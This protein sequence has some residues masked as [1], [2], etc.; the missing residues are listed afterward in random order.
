MATIANN[1]FDNIT[2]IVIGRNEAKNLERC[3]RSIKK[4]N[5]NI[6]Y[7][8]SGSQDSSVSIAEKLKVNHIIQYRAK[9]STPAMSRSIG[10]KEASTEYIQF[11]DGDMKLEDGWIESA[12]RKMESDEKIAIVHG[13]KKVFTKNERDF[14]ILSDKKDWQPDYLQ[15]AYLIRTEK[16]RESGGLDER[17]P[18]E[19]ERDL[20]IRIRAIGSQVWYI[21]QLMASHYD[22]KNKARNFKFLFFSDSAATIII[23]LIKTLFNGNYLS[24]LFVYRRLILPLA[25][26]IL[27]V[28]ALF[29]GWKGI[30][31]LV[32]FQILEL[33][34]VKAIDRRGY[35]IIWKAGLLNIH[36]AVRIM[37][38]DTSF[39]I[40]RNTE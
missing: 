6:I 3:F 7:V 2:F 1:R 4:V 16:Y 8:D 14:F 36:R 37:N 15:G 24:Y 21:H 9:Y 28:V 35:F 23:P 13:Y 31:I 20:Y 26:D 10:A 19:E 30:I 39:A 22:F 18:G 17:F 38:R 32:A 33:I 25:L 27:S 12:L 29:F 34:Y 11:L 40:E 5:D